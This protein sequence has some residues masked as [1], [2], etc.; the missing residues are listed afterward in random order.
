MRI[1]GQ[2]REIVLTHHVHRAYLR[3]LPNF[4]LLAFEVA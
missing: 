3:R 1:C 2:C 4:K